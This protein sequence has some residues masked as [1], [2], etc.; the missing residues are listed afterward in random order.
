MTLFLDMV[1][2]DWMLLSSSLE[3]LS[4]LKLVITAISLELFDRTF[5]KTLVFPQF[6][7]NGRHAMCTYPRNL[8]LDDLYRG[9]TRTESALI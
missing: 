6:S 2:L 3:T 1:W 5:Q 7:S 8:V 9:L 4:C